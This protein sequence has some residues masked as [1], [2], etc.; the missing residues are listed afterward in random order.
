[1]GKISSTGI[2]VDSVDEVDIDALKQING[3]RVEAASFLKGGKYKFIPN[4]IN[5]MG[6]F[7]RMPTNPNWSKKYLRGKLA[8]FNP[9]YCAYKFGNPGNFR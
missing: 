5:L 7:L 4:I 3:Y 2:R 6:V 8:A 1:M 9:G